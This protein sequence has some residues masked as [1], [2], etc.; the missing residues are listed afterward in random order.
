MGRHAMLLQLYVYPVSGLDTVQLTLEETLRDIAGRRLPDSIC[1]GVS[2]GRPTR[3]KP[4]TLH[5]CV[6]REPALPLEVERSGAS[7]PSELTPHSGLG[8]TV[9][10]TNARAHVYVLSSYVASCRT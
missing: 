9:R 7:A 3:P 1:F 8:A 4:S 10:R 2:A 5:L 6:W